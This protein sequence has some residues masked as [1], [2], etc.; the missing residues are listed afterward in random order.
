MMKHDPM[1]TGSC[2][3]ASLLLPISYLISLLAK[4]GFS[5]NF[6]NMPSY[7]AINNIIGKVE[8]PKCNMVTSRVL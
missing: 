7:D 3:H 4:I 5:W 1:K 8:T 2:H 6:P